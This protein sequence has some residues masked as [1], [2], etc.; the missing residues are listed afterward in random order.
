MNQHKPMRAMAVNTSGEVII[1]TISVGQTEVDGAS[2]FVMVDPI[3]PQEGSF[4]F[5]QMDW[6]I[7]R[8]L[9]TAFSRDPEFMEQLLSVAADSAVQHPAQDPPWRQSACA[10]RGRWPGPAPAPPAR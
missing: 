5:F 10:C 6:N 3:D 7:G 2:R 1:K 9:I 8:N 4:V